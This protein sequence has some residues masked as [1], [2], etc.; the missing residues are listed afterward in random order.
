MPRFS[1]VALCAFIGAIVLT[2]CSS[3]ESPPPATVS[4]AQL[5]AAEARE[6]A[7]DAYI[8][9]NPMVDSYRIMHTYFVDETHPEYKAPWNEIFNVAR[10]FTHEDTALQYPNS[11][12]P[13]S[14]LGLDLRAEP[15]VLGVPPIEE[16]RYFSIQLIDLYTHIPEY[17][18][19]RTTGNGGGHYLL[20]GPGWTGETPAGIDKVIV[21]ETDLL[22]ALYRTQLFN[23]EDL[24]NV[25]AI[26]QAYTVQPL[27]AFLGQEP[28][29]SAPPIAFIDRL[30]TDELRSSLK[31]F[32]QLDFLLQFAPV[33]PSE[34]DLRERFS[35]I[36]IDTPTGFDADELSPEIQQAMMQ[37]IGDAWQEFEELLALGIKG[38]VTSGDIFGSREHLQNNYLYRFGAAVQ[39]IW[40]NAEVEAFYPQYN[41]DADG[42][43]LDGANAYTLRFGPDDLPPVN[44]FWSLTM[45]RLPEAL[46]VENDIGRYLLNSTTLDDYVRDDDGGITLYIQKDAPGDDRMNNWLPAPAGPF[47]INM[48]LYWPADAALDR[49][50]TA[51]PMERVTA[52]D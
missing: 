26:Q 40:G 50:W 6:I 49:T 13:Y 30:T 39:G 38:E 10:V 28:P 8:Y 31:V 15:M 35:R 19:S 29:E 43:R 25:V 41:A 34:E 14:F 4:E 20:A 51:P 46:L 36:G 3:E 1:T 27:S 45:Y 9:G 52:S 18:G 16:S 7:R 12:T 42:Q 11:D 23:P 37:G 24:D 33:H 48:R 5:T 32:E 22:L 17:I 2:A 47:A 44:A 21:V